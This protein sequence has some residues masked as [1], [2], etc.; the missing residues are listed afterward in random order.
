ML[1]VYLILLLIIILS[2]WTIYA[3]FSERA[4]GAAAD[5]MEASQMFK[6]TFTDNSSILR[7]KNIHMNCI[8]REKEFSFSV[9]SDHSPNGKTVDLDITV[10]T[11]NDQIQFLIA[12]RTFISMLDKLSSNCHFSKAAEIDLRGKTAY[13]VGENKENFIQMIQ[14]DRRLAEAVRFL[15]F[16]SGMDGFGIKNGILRIAKSYKARFTTQQNIR[17]LI[18]ELSIIVDALEK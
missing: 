4:S 1:A 8:Y 7:G 5:L 14:Q 12:P 6:G 17:A 16:E 18:H 9:A 11:K 15:T 10:R 2:T 13:V 3:A